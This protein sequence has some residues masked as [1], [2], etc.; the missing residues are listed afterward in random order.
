MVPGGNTFVDISY[1]LDL[2]YGDVNW[3]SVSTEILT[4]LKPIRSLGSAQSGSNSSPAKPVPIPQQPLVDSQIITSITP[5]FST[6]SRRPSPQEIALINQQTRNQQGAVRLSPT[7]RQ[8][9]Q[10]LQ[11]QTSKYLDPFVGGWR[12]A[13]NQAIFVYPST[14]K[15]KERQACI[16][17]EKGN[18]QDLQIGVAIGNATGT[19]IN[20]G[21]GRLFNINQT[22]T[23]ALR[24]P[25]SNQLIAV[26][27]APLAANL[28]ENHRSAMEENGCITSF[29][30]TAIATTSTNSSFQAL[31]T[32]ASI[33]AFG[34]EQFSQSN[35]ALAKIP[36]DLEAAKQGKYTLTSLPKLDLLTEPLTD[37]PEKSG[38]FLG[39][40]KGITLEDYLTLKLK[41][42]QQGLLL[43]R[44]GESLSTAEKYLE[45]FPKD[46]QNLHP[47]IS[48]ISAR[49][50]R[51]VEQESGSK[52]GVG[53]RLV[54]AIEESRVAAGNFIQET[55]KTGFAAFAAWRNLGEWIDLLPKDSSQQRGLGLAVELWNNQ[56]YLNSVSSSL[57]DILDSLRSGDSQEAINKIAELAKSTLEWLNQIETKD[58]PQEIGRG[59]FLLEIREDALALKEATDLLNASST[60]D[61]LNDLDRIY[62]ITASVNSTVDMVS[63]VISL[64]APEK[65]RISNIISKGEAVKIVVMDSIKFTYKDEVRR[66]YQA[67][68]SQEKA[69]QKMIDGLSAAFDFSGEGIGK[70]LLDNRTDVVRRARNGVIE[71]STRETVYPR[72]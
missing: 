23:L 51:A 49:F 38:T 67:L 12:T 56:K 10:T 39:S 45:R 21:R 59:K 71:V 27:A 13:D 60:K 69:N 47:L 70:Y 32:F 33:K 66:Y 15:G 55:A 9:R 62:L 26:Y 4:S 64:M 1:D 20:V 44:T 61:V 2:D 14:R 18:T 48:S 5:P 57:P 6:T 40:R 53:E 36:S 31:K 17:I 30:S 63:K 37:I 11:Q 3:K 7:Q 68:Q 58:K 34:L 65:S 72:N 24:S 16:I 29:P 35:Q 25:E 28:T 42:H 54:Y 50:W 41:V 43:K 52:W 46:G 19:D 22:N 8:A